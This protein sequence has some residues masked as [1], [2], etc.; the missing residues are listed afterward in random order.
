MSLTDRASF[1]N[2]RIP[3]DG[4][5]KRL[6]TVLYIEV[7]YTGATEQFTVGE[8][9]SG[10]TS[11]VS[12]EIIEVFPTDATTGKFF[13]VVQDA[14]TTFQASENI[15]HNG[16]PVAV[17]N[18]T[19]VEY[20]VPASIIVGK[21]SPFHGQAVDKAGAAYVRFTE[22]AQQLDSYGMSRMSQQD[23]FQCFDFKY[24]LETESFFSQSSTAPSATVSHLTYEHAVALDTD[25]NS[26]S[27]A[28]YISAIRPS[29]FP[30]TSQMF[31]VSVAAGDAGKAGVVRRWGAYSNSNGFYFELS[32]TSLSLVKRSNSSGVVVNT[33]VAQADW[34]DPLMAGDSVDGMV[35]DVSKV[36]TYWFNFQTMTVG[37]I[38]FGV[39]NEAGDRVTVHEITE[40]NSSTVPGL[41]NSSVPFRVEQFNESTVASPSRLKLFAAEARAEGS[42]PED[43]IALSVPSSFVMP[44]M[45]TISG[46]GT[47]PLMSF[48]ANNTFNGVDNYKL[49][50]PSK[51]S[52]YVSGT[53][54][55]LSIVRNA[56]LNTSSWTTLTTRSPVQ[57]DMAATSVTSGSYISSNIYGVGITQ[58]ETDPKV[59]HPKGECLTSLGGSGFWDYYTIVAQ[60]VN[61]AAG[62]A[63]VKLAMNWIDY[64]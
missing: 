63:S 36:N 42:R 31:T 44:S 61:P 1:S 33:K 28:R 64:G 4:A 51:F 6:G 3:P 47:V 17:V 53:E 26:G 50:I 5:G 15:T 16:I 18:G 48:R 56:T 30:G 41:R 49:T 23:V 22:G 43:L 14:G 20:H 24:G 45:V 11:L 29:I 13:G 38:R 25:A 59:W 57:G 2:Y 12:M 32:G 9:V 10:Q 35:L 55:S 7:S 39:L 58:A 27:Y 19:P 62:D 8:I 52:V 46:S 37:S 54:V 40:L 21:N 60:K 34:S